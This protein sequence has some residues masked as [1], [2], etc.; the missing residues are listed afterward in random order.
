MLLGKHLNKYYLKYAFYFIAG[1]LAL[2]AIDYIQ[3]LTPEYLGS[4]VGLFEK[5]KD[6]GIAVS[7]DDVL[8]LGLKVVGVAAILFIGRFLWRITL[9]YASKKIEAGLRHKMFLKAERLSTT[10]Y[11]NNKVGT[12]M[13]WFTND[14]ETIEEYLG[15][16]TI[17]LIDALFLSSIVIVKML[18]L[19]WQMSL[20]IFI[21]VIL[22]VIWGALVEKFM[23]NLWD[24]RQKAYD[25]LYDFSQESFTGIRVIKAFVKENQEIRAF[26]KTAKKNKDTNIR[27]SRISVLFDVFI[28]VILA[29]VTC[30]IL[31]F[32][33]WFVF[34][35]VDGNP[36]ILFNTPVEIDAESL[37]V[38]FGY[39]QEL[40]WPMMALGQIV[41][42]KSRAKASLAR[43]S[44]FLEADEDIKNCENPKQIDNILGEITFNNLSFKYPSRDYDN[45]KNLNFTIKA[46]ET[47]GVVGKIGCG[48]STIANLLVRLYNI[49][50]N[51]L[52]IDGVDIM[53][54]DLT[55]LRDNIAYVPQ[56][57]FLFS[58]K[59]KNN[60]AFHEEAVSDEDIVAASEFAQVHDN[61]I[62]FEK[63]YDTI[64]GERGVT[65]SGGQK[66]RISIARAYIKKAPIM[67]LDDSVSAVDTKTEE[68]ILK[69]IKTL[70][71]G[72]TTIVIASRVSTVASLDKILVLN[73]GEVEAFDTHENLLKTSKTY[74]RMVYLQELEKEM[75]GGSN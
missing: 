7:L 18:F 22:I 6:T 73:K 57:N 43:I 60:I 67:I 53:D 4:L 30:C 20:L 58:D 65:L 72:Q 19:S 21:P 56:D 17:M 29:I 40:I 23:A 63:G 71:K 10:Y 69:N 13:S 64:S 1:I 37:V 36:I 31:G 51:S 42:M 25:S 46:G 35:A 74:A 41:S 28:S 70:R 75:E 54:L 12:V 62:N 16:G 9:F 14:L 66:Q 61:I 38:F 45:L 3:T 55:F 68:A 11:Q 33:G 50:P 39:F 44:N 24:S 8:P 15:W 47:I 27:F 48:K 49:N 32:G 2:I 59:I 26:A 34:A 5:S 52:L